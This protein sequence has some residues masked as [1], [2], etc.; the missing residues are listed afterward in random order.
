MAFAEVTGTTAVGT[1]E[2]SLATNTSYDTADAQTDDAMVQLWL[3]LSD[4]IAGDQL[5]IRLYEK[6]RSSD[7]QRIAEEWIL[8]GAQAKPNWASP[9]VVLMHGWDWTV[10]ALAGTITVNWSIRKVT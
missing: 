6:A 8:S 10:D 9:A 4:M 1:T 2:W 5:Q 7:T 3:D